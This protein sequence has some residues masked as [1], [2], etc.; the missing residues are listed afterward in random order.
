VWNRTFTIDQIES[1]NRKNITYYTELQAALKRSSAV[2]VATPTYT[3]MDISNLAAKLGKHLY[4]E[5]PISH[6]MIG[7][8]ELLKLSEKIV[9]EVGCQLRN[10]PCLIKL[11]DVLAESNKVAGYRMEMG[12]RLDYWRK[13][14]DFK[15]SYTSHSNLGGGA[16][17]ELVHM[18]DLALW[19]FGPIFQVSALV[20]RRGVLEID[21]DDFSL[22]MIEHC[23]GI[24]GTI[25]LDMVS[26]SYHCEIQ[27]I[28]SDY[29][30]QFDL[31]R[32]L[33]LARKS[34]KKHIVH[35]VGISYKRNSMF[36][37]HMNHFI[38]RVGNSTLPPKCSLNAGV[39]S[40]KVLIA[41]M[42]SSTSGINVKP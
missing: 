22:L 35:N 33:L 37:S 41:S 13:N 9:V 24:I 16:L 23:N 31:G 20:K 2:V 8:V 27:C 39:D 19:Y 34:E 42:R 28:T 1:L 40:L 25:Q 38:S 26:T 7:V 14:Y 17:F 36:L 12:H 30:Y 15:K 18:I 10:H 3:H 29:I 5:K 21:C 6:N 4:L 32:G 11:N